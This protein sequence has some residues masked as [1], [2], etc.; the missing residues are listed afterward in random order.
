MFSLIWVVLMNG[1]RF[2]FFHC[3]QAAFQL[4][5]SMLD[6]KHLMLRDKYVDSRVEHTNGIFLCTGPLMIHPSFG[7]FANTLGICCSIN[8]CTRLC[9]SF[10]FIMFACSYLMWT[11]N[12]LSVYDQLQL[13]VMA[14]LGSGY[15]RSSWTLGLV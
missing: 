2:C 10:C 11:Q 3:F 6:Y 4:V 9:M 8:N 12:W 5:S 15:S 14:S 1:L 7:A 13:C